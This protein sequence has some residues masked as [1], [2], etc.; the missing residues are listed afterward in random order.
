MLLAVWSIG[1]MIFA[2]DAVLDFIPVELWWRFYSVYKWVLILIGVYMMSV[3]FLPDLIRN[4]LAV[5]VADFIRHR[6]LSSQRRE[7]RTEA[8]PLPDSGSL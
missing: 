6:F 5:S 4:R 8:D 7:F 1:I 3:V 2:V